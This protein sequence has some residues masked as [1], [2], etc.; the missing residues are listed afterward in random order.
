MF[1][2]AILHASMSNYGKKKKAE[3][4]AWGGEQNAEAQG[5]GDMAHYLQVKNP[6][7]SCGLEQTQGNLTGEPLTRPNQ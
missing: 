4:T 2:T 3:W 7:V 6:F 5:V 1:E